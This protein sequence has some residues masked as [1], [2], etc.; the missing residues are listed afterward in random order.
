MGQ[1]RHGLELAGVVHQHERVHVVGRS[2]GVGADALAVAGLP[3]DP[4]VLEGRAESLAILRSQR[5]GGFQ[6][7][8]ARFGRSPASQRRRAERAVEV[9][10]LELLEAQ[11]TRAQTLVAVQQGKRVVD[12]REE[13]IEHGDGHVVAVK[14]RRQAGL[15][16]AGA[17]HEQVGLDRA[18]EA[19]AEGFAKPRE[20]AEEDVVQALPEIAIARAAQAAELDRCDLDRLALRRLDLR[21][22]HLG[23][24]QGLTDVG[25]CRRDQAG[26]G[27]ELLLPRP[28]NVRLVPQQVAQIERERL[29]PGFG[30]EERLDRSI[31]QREQLRPHPREID[32]VAGVKQVD[33]LPVRLAFAAA[34]VEV[35]TEHRVDLRAAQPPGVVR[36]GLERIRERCRGVPQFPP[37]TVEPVHVRA[38]A[39]EIGEEL[40]R[41]GVELAELPALVLDLDLGHA[42]LLRRGKWIILE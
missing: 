30:L 12:V 42:V 36:R 18:V 34:H 8:A 5:A 16:I 41:G 10:A 1:R 11:R 4:A 25:R 37:P 29:Q 17:S 7:V 21:P 23:V 15:V 26:V 20:T 3:I 2:G 33:L 28:E 14:R 13:S 6:D 22:G 32:R 31:G 40:L 38:K 27:E 39:L 24:E 9:V 19:L 35:G